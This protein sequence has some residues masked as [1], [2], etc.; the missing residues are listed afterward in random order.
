MKQNTHPRSV[1][2]TLK[3][4]LLAGIASSQLLHTASAEE[5]PDTKDRV[6]LTPEMATSVENFLEV[7]TNL[8]FEGNP[9]S[10]GGQ[11]FE[12]GLGVHAPSKIVF[13]L[14]G[15]YATFHV[16]PGPDDANHGVL[17]MKILVD[18][19][20]VWASGEVRSRGYSPMPLEFPVAGAQTLTLIVDECGERGG[21]H[22]SWGDAY[23]VPAATP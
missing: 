5:A 9:I 22:A 12:R 2:Q 20:E 15:K 23:L 11:P 7:Q 17:E 8:N 4:L 19:N 21:D 10:I 16:V 14:D 1:R 3:L 13:P 18:D 6:Y